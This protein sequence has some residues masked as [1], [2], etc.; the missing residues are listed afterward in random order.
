[1]AW[2]LGKASLGMRAQWALLSQGFWKGETGSSLGKAWGGGRW[3]K[4]PGCPPSYS[5]PMPQT[6]GKT[7]LEPLLLHL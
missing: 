2:A 3:E 5:C 1:M 7:I 4:L 6:H